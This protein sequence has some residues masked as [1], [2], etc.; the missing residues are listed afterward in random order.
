MKSREIKEMR[1]E[2]IKESSKGFHLGEGSGMSHHWNDQPVYQ[3][4]V[5]QHSTMPTFLAV[6]NE[7]FQEHE[8]LENYFEEYES[9]NHRFKYHLIFQEFFQIKDNRRPRHHHIS[10]GFIQNHDRHHTMG[11]FF[12]P[13]FDGSSKCSTKAWVEKLDI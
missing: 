4:Q 12:L 3:P 8:S 11:R 6:G 13:N 7:G 10:G 1:M 5:S 2:I 9:Q